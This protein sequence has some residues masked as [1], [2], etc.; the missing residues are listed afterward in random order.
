VSHWQGSQ[1]RGNSLAM[2]GPAKVHVRGEIALNRSNPILEYVTD[3][4]HILSLSCDYSL[5]AR[6]VHVRLPQRACVT[7]VCSVH[8]WTVRA[9]HVSIKTSLVVKRNRPFVC[10]SFIVLLTNVSAFVCLR[11]FSSL[12]FQARPQSLRSRWASTSPWA[13]L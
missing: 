8:P 4:I 7:A 11:M 5:L 12:L 13:M 9:D 1:S 6:C 10:P 3:A 2:P